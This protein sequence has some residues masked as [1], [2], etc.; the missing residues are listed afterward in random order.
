MKINPSTTVGE[1]IPE[2]NHCDDGD[3]LCKFA[4]NWQGNPK[5]H[6]WICNLLDKELR[7]AVKMG[8]SFHK[9]KSCPKPS[10]K[11]G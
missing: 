6:Q 11:E 1:L 3:S 10:V 2:G 7:S 8:G 4:T 5:G 9:L